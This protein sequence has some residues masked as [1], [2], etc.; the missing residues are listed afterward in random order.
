MWRKATKIEV[1]AQT[2]EERNMRMRTVFDLCDTHKHW[3]KGRK[4]AKLVV[5]G[6]P[7]LPVEGACYPRYCR[8]KPGSDYYN[9]YPDSEFVDLIK[10][11]SVNRVHH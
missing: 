6:G 4:A 9:P 5:E 10:N 7:G 11:W 8:V 3:G 2:R 1:S